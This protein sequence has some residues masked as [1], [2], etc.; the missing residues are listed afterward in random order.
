MSEL[1]STD[2][3]SESGKRMGTLLDEMRGEAGTICALEDGHFP[4]PDPDGR[5]RRKTGELD[6]PVGFDSKMYPRVLREVARVGEGLVA[7]RAFVRLRL[8]HVDLRVHLQVRLRTEDLERRGERRDEDYST[9]YNS[10]LPRHR[11]PSREKLLGGG[12]ERTAGPA[13]YRGK[14]NGLAGMG[15]RAYFV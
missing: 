10:A 7:L 1:A 8:P 12:E 14:R 9:C 5:R 3:A 6:S 15:S 13:S 4:D 11:R 2:L